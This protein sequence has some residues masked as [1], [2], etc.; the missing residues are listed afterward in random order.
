M[1]QKSNPDAENSISALSRKEKI[2]SNVLWGVSGA[3]VIL[4]IALTILLKPSFNLLKSQKPT[5]ETTKSIA[6]APVASTDGVSD[7]SYAPEKKVIRALN[8]HTEVARVVRRNTEE[9]IVQEGDSIFN[10]AKKFDLAAE[11][12]FWANYNALGGSIDALSPGMTLVIPPYDGVYY[13]WKEGDTFQALA[14]KFYV[15]TDTIVTSPYNNLDLANPTVEPDTYIMIPGGQEEMVDWFASLTADSQTA[16]TYLVSGENGC[17]NSGG[18]VGDG[19]F[20]NPVPGSTIIGNDYVPG[21]HVG[22]DLGSQSSNTVVAADDGVVIYSG[23]AN[24]GY[25]ITILIDHGNG[26]QSIYAHLS[27]VTVGCGASVGQGTQIG[28]VGS[29]GNSTGPHLHFEIR[30]NGVADNP[31]NYF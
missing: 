1:S 8:P 24:G 10:I 20:G 31:H 21:V 7:V 9:Y 30:Y 4:A 11:T 29:T 15:D 19:F 14:D 18:A 22:V 12:V 25:G 3:M 23:W 26:F 16:V 27:T 2:I 5:S 13:K 6:A 17:A 28:V